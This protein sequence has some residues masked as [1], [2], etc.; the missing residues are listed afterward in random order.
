MAQSLLKDTKM[1]LFFD[2][3]LDEDGKPVLESK[4]YS[5]IRMASTPDQLDQA[6]QALRA[7]CSKNLV[8]VERDDRYNIQP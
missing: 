4:T 6:A 1:K 7:L 3:G 2:G 8:V 5:N